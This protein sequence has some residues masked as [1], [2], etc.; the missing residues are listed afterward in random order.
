MHPSL[1]AVTGAFG[2]SGRY[3]AQRLLAAHLPVITLSNAPA[4]SNPFPQ[5][6]PVFPLD[7]QHPDAL[8]Q[9]LRGV[10]TLYNT[11]WIRFNYRSPAF[12][13]AAAVQN[14]LALFHAARKAGV[15]RIVHTSITNPS[16]DSPLG[17][18]R[19]KAQLEQALESLGIP[20]AILRPA[21]L[22]G[23]GDILINNIAFLLRRFPCFLLFGRGD[24]RLQPIH[25]DD[26]AALAVEHGQR[27]DNRV[28]QAI[29]PETFTYRALV[30]T[31]AAA[32]GL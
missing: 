25:V 11:Y 28:I 7:F 17:Y 6:V 18:F 2:F 19:G 5:N 13:H 29:G 16:L 4:S 32:L 26:F 30:A 3:I 15:Q 10:T 24:Y 27:T 22:F 8:V 14:T 9:A 20:Y 1:H 21:V 12:S 23:P 31:L